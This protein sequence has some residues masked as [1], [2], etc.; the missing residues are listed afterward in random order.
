MKQTL[1][2]ICE[3]QPFYSPDNTAEMKERGKLIR[4]ELSAE[5]GSIQTL[6]T[7]KLGL[8]GTDFD[9][10]SSDGIGRKTEAPWVR[11]YSKRMSPKPTDG[12]YCVIHFKRDGSGCYL[13]LGC[14]STSWNGGSLIPLKPE[15]LKIKT[16]IARQ[17]I[18]DQFGDLGIFTDQIELGAKAPL[19]QTFERATA[20]AKFIEYSQIDKTDF[21]ELLG[22]LATFLQA[23]YDAQ[24][25]GFDLSEADQA[26]LEIEQVIRPKRLKKSSQGFGLSAPEKKVVEL[27]AMGLA[28]NW[29]KKNGYTTKDT[30]A[31]EPYDILAE[32]DGFKIKVEVKGTTSHDPNAILMTA[33]EVTLHQTQKTQTALAIVSSIK[34]TKGATPTASGGKLD[35]RI[36]WDI[37]EW[38]LT[39]TAFRVERK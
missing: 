34:L 10:S 15:Q 7:S 22:G 37:D 5:I 12:Y 32:K 3:L 25:S 11:F 27:R 38:V 28:N 21:A 29:L 30:S 20:V 33:N 31:T 26:Q 35:M 17:A 14:G 24:S 13:T 18:V 39:P 2:R 6:L 1:K 16:G 23:V 4:K 8:Y 9:I 19:P 36:G